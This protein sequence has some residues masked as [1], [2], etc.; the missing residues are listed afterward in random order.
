MSNNNDETPPIYSGTPVVVSS[1]TPVVVNTTSTP[2]YAYGMDQPY[3][4]TPYVASSNP[5]YAATSATGNNRDSSV[6]D[7][8]AYYPQQGGT[9]VSGVPSKGEPVMGQNP[10]SGSTTED[11]APTPSALSAAQAEQRFWDSVGGQ[12]RNGGGNVMIVGGNGSG[13]Q[14]IPITRTR[15]GMGEGEGRG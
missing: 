4:A 14:T 11:Y 1:G 10:N 7:V 13:G 5:T 2:S 9:F 8:V 6:V 3:N 12:P 15:N